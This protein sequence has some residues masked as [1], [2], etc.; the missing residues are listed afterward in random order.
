MEL[1]INNNN[2]IQV[3]LEDLNAAMVNG[4]RKNYD[5]LKIGDNHY[6]IIVDNKSYNLSVIKNSATSANILL[7]INGTSI[8]VHTKDELERLLEKMGMSLSGGAK[9]KELK[10]PMPG[11]VLNVLVQIGQSLQKDEP[12]LVL[13][14]MKMENVIKSPVEGVIES[15][16][17]KNGDKVD[18]NQVLIKFA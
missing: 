7:Q 11:L 4:E 14:A 10:A 3:E 17:V 18:K 8:E 5:I 16:T 2:T 12:L 1:I 6:N 15:I 9:I 13:E